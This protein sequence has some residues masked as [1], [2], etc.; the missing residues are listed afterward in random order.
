MQ[1]VCIETFFWLNIQTE[2]DRELDQGKL[3]FLILCRSLHT[4]TSVVPVILGIHPT[5]VENV[6]T[7]LNEK[8]SVA[9]I[10]NLGSVSAGYIMSGFPLELEKWES[11]FQSWNEQTLPENFKRVIYYFCGI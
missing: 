3:A 11:I 1:T 5:V 10:H 8:R 7:I 9:S 2:L 4:T 6:I